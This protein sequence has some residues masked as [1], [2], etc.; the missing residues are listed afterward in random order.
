MKRYA[1]MVLVFIL[2]SE[3]KVE[4]RNP[5]DRFHPIFKNNIEKNNSTLS[6][7]DI[8]PIVMNK[9][10]LYNNQGEHFLIN[11]DS[12]W[13][14]IVGPDHA[15]IEQYLENRREKGINAIIVDLVEHK[16]NGPDDAFGNSPF[17][18]SGDFSKPNDIYFENAAFVFE[19][20]QEK[21]MAVFVFPAYLGYPGGED[22]WYEDII[23]CGPT[24]MYAYGKYVANKYKDFKNI[25]WLI[26]GDRNGAI[27]EIH[28]M[29][30]G[31][32]EVKSN[33]IFSV[34]NARN[35]SGITM[36][37][38]QDRK[39]SGWIDLNTTYSECSST[40]KRLIEDYQRNFPFFYMEGT[41]E[42]EGASGICVRS[43]IYWSVLTGALGYFFGNY[44]L[45]TFY[46]IKDW[47]N[48]LNTPG[49]SDLQHAGDFFRAI[50]W[51]NLVPDINHTTLTDGYGSSTDATFVA[52]ARMKDGSS[53]IV[54]TPEQHSL[55]INMS[56]ISGNKSR[57][58]WF[59]P[60]TGKTEPVGLVNNS[61]TI[62]YMPPGT[63]DWVL[64]AQDEGLA[65]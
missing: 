24:T 3:I 6:G 50:P 62:S 48:A 16:I 21:G 14:L 7:A 55:S 5:G 38:N 25:I 35:Q 32:E 41:Y 4:S 44:P 43:Q 12:P 36:Y 11:G 26:G 28:A 53:V 8:F 20:A 23:R 27:E 2:L 51:F 40:P 64:I 39:P 61:G 19:K 45:Y 30:K 31:I 29:V 65:K 18:E 10:Y 17:L 22:G 42:G 33:Q 56:R 49:S 34:H 37:P 63:G 59:Q 15:G 46:D 9:G 1:L 58:W 54:Y 47:K 57:V 13:A 52:A 60:S